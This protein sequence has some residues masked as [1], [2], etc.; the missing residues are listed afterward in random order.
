MKTFNEKV[1]EVIGIFDGSLVLQSEADEPE[2]ALF[3]HVPEGDLLQDE[4]L[5]DLVDDQDFDP[6]IC[7]EVILLHKGSDMMAKVLGWKHDADGNLVGHKIAS[8]PWI[9]NVTKSSSLMGSVSTLP[10]MP[11]LST[12]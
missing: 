4:D 5:D 3:I 11:L 8:Q 7:A 9:P 1:K 2:E 10:T 6:L 12:S